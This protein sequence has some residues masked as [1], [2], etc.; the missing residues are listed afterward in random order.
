MCVLVVV[1]LVWGLVRGVRWV[2]ERWGRYWG[3]KGEGVKDEDGEGDGRGEA[4]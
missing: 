4:S 2:W 3:V 1:G